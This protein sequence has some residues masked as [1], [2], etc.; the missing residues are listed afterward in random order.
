MDGD[1]GWHQSVSTE[2][3]DYSKPNLVTDFDL[4]T[5]FQPHLFFS[6]SRPEILPS[7]IQDARTQAHF[8]LESHHIYIPRNL[9]VLD[10][11]HFEC[12]NFARWSE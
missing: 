3:L 2:N 5:P 10:R 11:E 7:S 6:S 9:N 8:F 4:E 12:L 1:S